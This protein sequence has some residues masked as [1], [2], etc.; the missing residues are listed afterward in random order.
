MKKFA[1]LLAVLAG[2]CAVSPSAAARDVYRIR[3]DM[4]IHAVSKDYVL[5]SIA[6][7]NEQDASLIVIEIDTPGG[8]VISVE[9]IQRAI[10][11]SKAPV[12]AFVTPAGARATS[13]GALVAIACDLVA[14]APG[15]SIGSAHPISGLPFSKDEK[16]KEEGNDPQSETEIAMLKFVNDL[17]AHVRSIA[18]NRDRDVDACE[19]MVRKATS[20]TE[21]EALELGVIELTA[22]D[23]PEVFAYLRDTPLKRFSGEEE[24]VEIGA[25]PTVTAFSM[26]AREKFLTSLADPTLAYILFLLG[27]VGLWIEFKS[28]GLIFP[29]VIGGICLLLYLMSLPILPVN[30]VGLLLVLLGI[31]FFILEVKVV[32]FGILTAGGVISLVI[33]GLM[34]YKDGPIPEFRLSLVAVVPIALVF[35]AIIVLLLFF[36][37][38]ALGNPVSTGAEGMI[39]QK[40]TVRTAIAPPGRGKVF[41]FG[42]LWEAESS[43]PLEAGSDI[44]VTAVK[45]GMVLVVEGNSITQ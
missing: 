31:V 8:F 42:E 36:A 23:L 6:L 9:S 13:G 34:M 41:V 37:V 16:K 28:P 33:G 1:T 2:L 7:A 24:S 43:V 26:T 45:D 25:D 18:E 4:P 44:V 3:L 5:R 40:G 22:K 17:A 32:S 35:S 12:V 20:Y 38:K 15:T 39:G 27:V 19:D 29:G 21:K 11:E 10:L 30:I 14:M